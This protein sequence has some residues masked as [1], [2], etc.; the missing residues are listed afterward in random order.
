MPFG[1]INTSTDVVKGSR[2]S[3]KSSTTALNII[4]RMLQY[5]WANTLV[6]RRTGKTNRAST[7]K[8]LLWAI[9]RLGVEDYFE[10]NNTLPEIRTKD[11]RI[12]MFAGLDEPLKLTSITVPVGR[13]SWVWL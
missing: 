6:L 3:K 10:I 8:Q 2:G 11:G 9:H 13:L 5:P 4:Y 12:I 1:T 7:F